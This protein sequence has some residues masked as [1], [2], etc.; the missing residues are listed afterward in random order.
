MSEPTPTPE[1][2]AEVFEAERRN[3]R[4]P[5]SFFESVVLDNFARALEQRLT[6]ALAE[7]ARLTAERD[8]ALANK[9]YGWETARESQ[10]AY[11]KERAERDR[12]TAERDEARKASYATGMRSADLVRIEELAAENARLTADCAA[13][14]AALEK[15]LTYDSEALRETM[16]IWIRDVAQQALATDHPGKVL[17]DAAGKA[18]QSIEWML[19]LLEN[20][21]VPGIAMK[22]RSVCKEARESLAQLAPFAPKAD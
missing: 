3:Y 9:K 6:A 18:S 15:I 7:N 11:E 2:D 22:E 13:L 4:G 14:R 10:K 21:D 17:L 16:L 20:Q 1:T 19:L 5:I 12:L 8:D